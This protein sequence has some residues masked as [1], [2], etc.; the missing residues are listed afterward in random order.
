ML[1]QSSARR[2][3]IA[4]MT[5]NSIAANLLMMLLLGGG[6]WSTFTIQKEV[7][8]NFLLDNVEISV[9]YP[10]AA[11]EEV[12]QGILQPIEQALRDVDGI[13]E[14]TS[15]SREGRAYVEVQ[16]VAGQ[17][18][19]KAFQ[20]IDQAVNRIRTFPEQI[21][22]PEVR[23]DSRQREVMRVDLYGEI[24][25][26]ALRKLGE[27]LRDQ[28]QAHE[29][30]TQ[31]EFWNAPPYVTHVEIPRQTLREYGLTL[32]GIANVIRRSSQDVAAGSVQSNAGEILLRVKGR[33]QFASEFAAIEIMTN[34]NG[35]SVKLGDIANIRDGFEEY[36]FQQQFDQKPSIEIEVYRVGNQSP[37]DVS[38]AVYET[39]ALFEAVLPPGVEPG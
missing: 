15:Y 11:P 4:W 22:Q 30:I 32:S 24:E 10:G 25:R 6:I 13:H 21:E 33:K 17:P 16:L 28:L 39:M 2:G 7:F 5:K 36:G 26:K 8:P 14:I 1:E 12:E 38:D 19:M 3:P 29:D 9:S 23:L 27:Q 18:R 31:L 34:R 37:Q 35:Q 20:D